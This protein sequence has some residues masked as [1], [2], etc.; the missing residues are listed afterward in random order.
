M[1]RERDDIMRIRAYEKGVA[2]TK[3]ALKSDLSGLNRRLEQMKPCKNEG[4][5][6][7]FEDGSCLRCFADAGEACRR[8]R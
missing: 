1:S 3:N 2:D 4:N 5:V 6:E 8:P 7:C